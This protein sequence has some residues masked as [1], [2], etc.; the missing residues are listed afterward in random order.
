VTT[1]AT[2][3]TDDLPEQMRI[4]R[5]K[6][7]R[8]AQ[9]G[10]DPYVVSVPI[11]HTIAAVRAQHPD[12]PVDTATGVEVGIAGRVIF[13]RNTGK[14][15]FATLRAGD[16]SEIQAMLSLDK[17]G[18]EALDQWKDLVDLGD[19][20]FIRGEVITSKRGELSVLADEWRMAAKSLRPLPVAHKPLNEETRVRQRYVDLIVRPEAQAMA[21]MRVDVMRS[22]RESL[23]S[24]GFL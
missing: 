21:R 22:V 23:T 15:C 14:L 16:G 2:D 13:A 7:D 19:H 4:R 9:A 3:P 6:R 10:R 17:V 20:V 8:L 12:L 1:E 11:T 24:R 5:E 18:E